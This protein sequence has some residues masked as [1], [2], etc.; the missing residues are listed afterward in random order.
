M[1]NSTSV[2]TPN[3]KGHANLTNQMRHARIFDL[4]LKDNTWVQAITGLK[5]A[6]VPPPVVSLLGYDLVRA[7]NDLQQPSFL[8]LVISDWAGDAVYERRKLY[9][10]FRDQDYHVDEEFCEVTFKTSGLVLHIGDAIKC[11]E[12][13]RM[14]EPSR[15]FRDREG[16]LSLQTA[17]LYYD[18]HSLYEI[19]PDLIGGIDHYSTEHVK[20]ICSIRLKFGNGMP[21]YR[22][23]E[24]PEIPL[25]LVSRP[26]RTEDGREWI[27]SWRLARN[28]EQ[29]WSW[30]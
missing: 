10:S 25:R 7:Y 8:A 21:V 14:R 1:E 28:D 12:W 2:Q 9:E 18:D 27:T 3:L 23:V 5:D 16:S 20:Y 4:I 24:A 6:S 15:L 19:G 11:E 26:T 22:V 13:I 17:V 29:T 30:V